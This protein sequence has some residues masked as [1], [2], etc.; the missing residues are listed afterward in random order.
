L[1][2]GGGDFYNNQND[3]NGKLFAVQVISAAKEGCL[4]FKQAYELT[5]LNDGAFQEYAG[6]LGI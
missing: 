3:L 1:D 5:G 4:G 2:G 6:W